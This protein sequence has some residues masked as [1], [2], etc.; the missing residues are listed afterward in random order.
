MTAKPNYFK[1]GIFV[2]IGVLLVIGGVIFFS[3]GILEQ[4]K[5]Y[6]ETYF[7]DSVSG[8]NVGAQLQD[9][10]VRIG[11]VERVSFVTRQYI[12]SISEA[13]LMK[14]APYVLV[15]CSIDTQNMRTPGNPEEI[16]TDIERAVK[17]GYRLRLAT[18]ILTG[19]AMVEGVFLDPN[20]YPPLKVPWK[21]DNLYIPSAAG[22]L[23]SIKVSVD[24]IL[25]EIEALDF[26]KLLASAESALAAIENTVKD[27]NVPGVTSEA[28]TLF[29]EARQT[30]AYI[31][32]LLVTR[33]AKQPTANI[34]DALEKL[35]LTLQRIDQMLSSQR[36]NIDQTLVNL[37]EASANIRDLTENLKS[38]PSEIIFSKPPPPPLEKRK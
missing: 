29:A 14:F 5:L 16:M 10:G 26:E 6:V 1:I 3:S 25:K 13:D 20:A 32:Q 4:K 7:A 17:A 11:Q 30:N 33:G 15:V 21:P 8:L 35:N 27:A 18:N 37:R 22:E 31:Q 38:N 19:Q 36:P 24:K 2:I 34:A 9:R 28:R 23:T 12:K